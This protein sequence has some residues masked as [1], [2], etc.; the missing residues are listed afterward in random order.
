MHRRVRELRLTCRREDDA[1]HGRVLLDDAL[2]TASLGDETR[3][4]VVRRMNLGAMPLRASATHWSRRIE[5]VFRATPPVAVRF[6]GAGAAD[7]NAVFFETAHEPWLTLAERLAAGQRCPEWFWRAAVPQWDPAS[8]VAETLRQCFRVLAERGGLA[9]TIVLG[10]RLHAQGVLPALLRALEPEDL[11]PLRI[12]TSSAAADQVPADFRPSADSAPRMEAEFALCWGARDARTH[13][14]ASLVL[15]RNTASG[16]PSA[17]ALSLASAPLPGLVRHLVQEWTEPA[18]HG[19]PTDAVLPIAPAGIWPTTEKPDG[20]AALSLG[21]AEHSVTCAGGLFFIVPLL[22]RAGLTR[23]LTT[24]A[25]GPRSVLPWQILRLA[26][27]HARVPANDP[28]LLALEAIPPVVE[29]VGRWLLAAHRQAV[30]L[31]GLTLRQLIDRPALVTLS[32]T[33]IDVLF[34]PGDADIRI[35]SAGLDLDPGWVPW[36]GRVIAFHYSRET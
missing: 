19:K 13:W 8:P 23:H 7:A 26:L 14:L 28:L 30:R 32:P 22:A 35:R 16:T 27:R 17:L 2:R 25:E 5:D 34:R 12:E 10:L 4:I 15:A 11:A 33:H 31:T 3:F 36:L 6:D 18:S 20:T 29:P 1:Q 24:L 9:L 21:P